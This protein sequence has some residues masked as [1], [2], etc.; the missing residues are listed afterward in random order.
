MIKATCVARAPIAKFINPPSEIAVIAFVFGIPLV[1][2]GAQ[3]MLIPQSRIR[4]DYEPCMALFGCPGQCSR[5]MLEFLVSLLF[6]CNGQP[7]PSA[8]LGC[9]ASASGG[10]S[11]GSYASIT[12]Y[13][14]GGNRKYNG[15]ALAR[16]TTPR[17][18]RHPL[19][20]QSSSLSNSTAWYFRAF[21]FGFA[22]EA[23]CS[24]GGGGDGLPW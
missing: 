21:L 17:D 11:E 5:P 23:P 1:K 15:A 16:A 13:P 7:W 19:N 14:A 18:R 22:S 12:Y 24:L 20:I 9:G 4:G 2:V 3:N 8:P 6:T 10:A